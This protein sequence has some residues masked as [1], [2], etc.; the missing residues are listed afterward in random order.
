M[1]L[2]SLYNVFFFSVLFCVLAIA[3]SQLSSDFYATS[4]PTAL[5][6]IKSAVKS[7]VSKERRMG[8]S[9]LRLHFHDCFVNASSFFSLCLSTYRFIC[10]T[11]TP[12]S[13]I[14]RMHGFIYSFR[15]CVNIH[16][17]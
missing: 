12:A 9:L 4:C 2:N 11:L 6:T 3:S 15:T 1:A 7:A 16:A 13:V 14:S 5:S 8:A 10:F 17:C